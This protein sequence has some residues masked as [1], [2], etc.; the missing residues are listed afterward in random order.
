MSIWQTKVANLP[1]RSIVIPSETK[2]FRGEIA[3]VDLSLDTKYQISIMIDLSNDKYKPDNIFLDRLE[4]IPSLQ[5]YDGTDILLGQDLLNVTRE[6]LESAYSI[7]LEFETTLHPIYNK[8]EEEYE[9]FK[10]DIDLDTLVLFMQSE[11]Q[12]KTEYLIFEIEHLSSF[13]GEDS[14]TSNDFSFEPG[15]IV[16]EDL[17]FTAE[18]FLTKIK[19]D[20]DAKVPAEEVLSDYFKE[21]AENDTSLSFGESLPLSELTSLSGGT[22]T[23]GVIVNDTTHD[24]KLGYDTN[25]SYDTFQFEHD[26]KEKFLKEAV[27]NPSH[28]NDS[29]LETFE[30][31]ILMNT[32]RP[33]KIIGALEFNIFKY[34]DRAK[35]KGSESEDNKKMMWYLSKMALLFPEEV[36]LYERYHLDKVGN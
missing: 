7:I 35:L 4:I 16:G 34:R 33:E 17:P 18:D 6:R 24:A 22:I 9:A 23:G 25:F 15:V 2:M 27:N 19:E 20:E 5:T 26:N 14:L 30:M 13:A 29:E 36:R 1:A 3:D 21:Y 32:S 10:K 28:Y 8:R 11:A 31:F 12:K